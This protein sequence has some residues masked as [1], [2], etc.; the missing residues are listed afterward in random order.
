MN[1]LPVFKSVCEVYRGVFA[2]FFGLLRAAWLPLLAYIVLTYLIEV[3]IFHYWNTHYYDQFSEAARGLSRVDYAEKFRQAYLPFRV[4]SYL[5]ILFKWIVAGFAAIAFHRFVLLGEHKRG[6]LNT[7]LTI[8]KEELQYA[9]STV[10]IGLATY[11]PIYLVLKNI[12]TIRFSNSDFLIFVG[13]GLVVVVLL[14]F[15]AIIRASLLLPHTAIGGRSEFLEI[16]KKSSE[17]TW[18]L[19]AYGMLTIGPA[20]LFV[21]ALRWFFGTSLFLSPLLF[22]AIAIV[23]M[24]VVLMLTIT[25][26]SVAY[27]EIIGLPAGPASGTDGQGDAPTAS[28]AS[29][30]A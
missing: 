21:P 13:A 4:V 2:H 14:L 29:V 26:L 16:W 23:Q 18:R 17:Q 25:T 12:P 20:L 30:P 1:T 15:G 6:W 24:L 27:R 22:L 7:G 10:K 19:A 8:D 3:S 28:E 11:L 9:W 5:L